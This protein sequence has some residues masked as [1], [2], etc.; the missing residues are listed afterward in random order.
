MLKS[1]K[2]VEVTLIDFVYTQY[3]SYSFVICC[4]QMCYNKY[5]KSV[6]NWGSMSVIVDVGSHL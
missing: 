4:Y 1:I 3:P 2:R 5:T 6:D